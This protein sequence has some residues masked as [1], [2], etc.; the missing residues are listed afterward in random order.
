MMGVQW[1][2][3][4]KSPYF[5]I[6]MGTVIFIVSIVLYAHEVNSLNSKLEVSKANIAALLDSARIVKTKNGELESVRLAL[7]AD[8]KSLKRLSESLDSELKKERGKVGTITTA[9]VTVKGDTI[10][11]KNIPKNSADTAWSWDYSKSDS[12]GS[13]YIEGIT[14]R[15]MTLITRDEISLKLITGLKQRASDN[16]LEIFIRTPFPGVTFSDIEGAVL[17]PFDYKCKRSFYRDFKIAGLSFVIGGISA[18]IA[19]LFLIRR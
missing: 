13:R 16:K 12:N 19:D 18:A 14:T 8:V 9:Q 15:A 6:A 1:L 17:D 3:I 10:K 2:K 7:I 4:L 5:W 11:I